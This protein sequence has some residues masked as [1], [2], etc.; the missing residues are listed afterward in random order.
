MRKITAFS[1]SSRPAGNSN[2]MLRYFLAGVGENNAPADTFYTHAIKIQDCSGCMRCNLIK[3]CANEKDDWK[4]IS[5]KIAS[6]DVLVFATPIYFH[7]VTASMKRLIDRF[8]SFN[9]VAITETGL[10]HTP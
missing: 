1:G 9:H 7:H 4:M 6:A 10:I 2:T 8:R 3:K 5:E